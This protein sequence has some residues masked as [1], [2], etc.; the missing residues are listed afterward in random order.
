M[1]KS[2]HTFKTLAKESL[3]RRVEVIRNDITDLLTGYSGDPSAMLTALEPIEWALVATQEAVKGAAV[4]LSTD[5]VIDS[6]LKQILPPNPE[7]K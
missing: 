4:E 2:P 1:K 5:I 3:L 6:R 7:E